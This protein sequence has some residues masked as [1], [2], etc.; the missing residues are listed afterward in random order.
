VRIHPVVAIVA[1][2]VGA[3][4]VGVLG[5]LLAIPV[6]ATIGVLIDEGMRWRRESNGTAPDATRPEGDPRPQPE[7]AAD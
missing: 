7:P 4:L 2:L 5:A 3:E 6:A 1:I